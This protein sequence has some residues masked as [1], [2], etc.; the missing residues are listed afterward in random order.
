MNLNRLNLRKLIAQYKTENVFTI[1]SASKV[2]Q[3]DK[4]IQDT[5]TLLE[6]RWTKLKDEQ[7][8]AILSRE[9]YQLEQNKIH[10]SLLE[11]INELK[12]PETGPLDVSTSPP[13]DTSTTTHAKAKSSWKTMLTA[14]ITLIGVLAGIAEISGYSIK[15]WW[16][17]EQVK[18]VETISKQPETPTKEIAPTPPAKPKAPSTSPKEPTITKANTTKKTAPV[19]EVLP[20]PKE[21]LTILIKTQKG[22]EHLVFNESEEVQFYFNVNR[23]CKLRTIYKLADGSLVLLD[24]DRLVNQAETGQ[25][26]QLSD[27]FEVAAP[28]GAEALYIFAQEKDFP[29][30][31][32]E[33][34]DGYAYI[35]EGL[36]IA[37][38]KTR[39]LKKKRAFAE[40]SLSITTQKNDSLIK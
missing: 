8:K 12:I 9:Q 29:A 37:L 1:L 24:N 34:L 7:R 23:P 31:I 19:K 21:K 11:L 10:N 16:E 6:S 27:G 20:A 3:A 5:I 33:E 36:P 39:G 38:S 26:V 4:D 28:F 2:V 25:W 40:S 14:F 18:K 13:I 32:T 35:K 17:G 22:T 15:D 30:L